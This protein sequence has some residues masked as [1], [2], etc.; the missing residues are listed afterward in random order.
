MHLG[1]KLEVGRRRR[2]RRATTSRWRTR[3]GR[4]CLPARSPTTREGLEPDDQ[5]EHRRRRHRRHR[6]AR[7]GRHRPRGRDAR[8]GGQGA[9]FK[10][11]GG[12]DAWPICLATNDPDEIV[13]LVKAIAPGFGGINLEDISAPRCFEIEQRLR[14][15]L[16]IPVFH[17]DQHGTAIVVLAALINAL[18]LVGKRLEDVRVVI[19]RRR[20]RGVAVARILLAAG[21]A[22]DRLRPRRRDPRGPRGLNAAEAA[23][24][25]TNPAAC[26][27]PPT[28]RCR[29]RRLRRALR[30]GRR[31]AR[32]ASRTMAEEAIVF[33]MA[34]PT[35][36]I[37]P[38]EI[39]AKVAVI[40]TG[41]SDYPNQINNVLA[42]PGCSAAPSTSALGD[43]RG[44]GARRASAIAVVEPDHD[45][46]PSTSFRACS[47]AVSHRPWPRPWPAPRRPAASPGAPAAEDYARTP[48]RA[49][50]PPSLVGDG[51]E[52]V[53]LRGASGRLDR[54]QDPD[55]DRHDGEDRQLHPRDREPHVELAQRPV[56]ECRE[57][58]PEREA[59]AR[60]R[61]AP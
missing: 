20:R 61:R 19:V 41:R 21:A 48:S 5:A 30:P 43:H 6:R 55:H 38:E 23:F 22:T 50:E 31:L 17:D 3:P 36:E 12:V 4:A 11:F 44:D 59:R 39:A 46:R 54:G 26:R 8:D 37:A 27:A 34:N 32:R 10:E 52:R 2:S 7:P 57:E 35:P 56:D 47:T 1:G 25:E 45:S 51:L 58:D 53:Q 14:A 28:R 13:A 18:A 29:R 15:E 42:F 40:A 16:D 49:S 33:A 60:R 9:A 24:A